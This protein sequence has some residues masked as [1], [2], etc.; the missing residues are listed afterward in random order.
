MFIGFF[1]IGFIVGYIVGTLGGVSIAKQNEANAIQ[2]GTKAVERFKAT[3]SKPPEGE[4]DYHA[5]VPAA[6]RDA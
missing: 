2:R 3:R 4:Q 5:D 6:W 1:I